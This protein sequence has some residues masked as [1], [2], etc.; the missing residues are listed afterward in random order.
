M[1]ARALAEIGE[2]R[3]ERT[4]AGPRRRMRRGEMDR[5]SA[6]PGRCA[7]QSPIG[8]ELRS[9]FARRLPLPPLLRR[10]RPPPVSRRAWLPECCA[11]S[12]P[13]ATRARKSAPVPGP[14]R[15]RALRGNARVPRRP[16][17]RRDRERQLHA[18]RRQSGPV[19][20]ASRGD[21]PALRA[22]SCGPSALQS[23]PP[24]RCGMPLR[25]GRH[26]APEKCPASRCESRDGVRA[27][28]RDGARLAATRIHSR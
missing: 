7:W 14:P 28:P 11:E 9:R 24:S 15:P 22:A 5:R 21:R 25:A 8:A 10:R 13:S 20:M 27:T 19:A 26:A 3:P 17:I 23:A 4:R 1:R 18:V 6:F 2:T 16:A 12:L